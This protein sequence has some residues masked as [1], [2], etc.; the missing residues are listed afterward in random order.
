MSSDIRPADHDRRP[1]M[2]SPVNIMSAL[3]LA[4][5]MAGAAA[6]AMADAPADAG[7][8]A[9]AQ[10]EGQLL[11]YTTLLEEAWRPVKEGF[12]RRHPGIE[13]SVVRA[14]APVNAQ[15]IVDEHGAGAVRADLFDGS[16]TAGLLMARQLVQPYVSPSAASIPDQFKDPDGHWTSTVLYYMTLGYNPAMIAPGQAPRSWQDLLAPQWKGKMAWSAELAPTS[17][18]GLVGNVLLSMGQ[19]AGM[20]YLRRLADQRIANIQINPRRIVGMVARQEYP[21]GLQVMVHHTV[22]AQREGQNVNWV[23]MEPLTATGNAIGIVRGAPHPNAARLMV[24]FIL[25]KEGQQL[26]KEADHIPSNRLVDSGFPEL[27]DVKV[28]FISPVLAA[29]HNAQWNAV[30]K[31]LFGD[32]PQ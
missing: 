28:R 21:I 13:V 6:P 12:E 16:S 3:L 1:I 15:K 32:P 5:G 10:R 29:E 24:D 27:A 20:D 30:L 8:L 4:L 11:W 17:A 7:R 22:M 9:A 18:Q 25:S 14:A 26:L 23:R 19:E 31:A 2:F